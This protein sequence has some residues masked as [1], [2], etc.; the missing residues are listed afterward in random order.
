M[1]TITL[2]RGRRRSPLSAEDRIA[3]WV[4]VLPA[5]LIYV[6]F[7]FGPV[8][9][10]LFISFFRWELVTPGRTFIGLDNYRALIHDED[11]W[12]AFRNTVWYSFGV[13]PVQ[14]ATGLVLAVLANRKIRG[15]TFFRTSFYFPS[16]SS[17][18]VIAIIFV[19]MFSSRG[20][21]N[22][23]LRALSLPT[24]RP[25]WLANP[26]GVIEL[27]LGTFGI[28]N[29]SVWL[30]GPSVALL[31]IMML[32]IWTTT[33]TLMVIFLAGLQNLP[34]DVYE[35]AALDGASRY[36]GFRDIT[37]PLLKPVILFVLTI[38]FIGCFQVFD[39][40]WIMSEGGPRKTTTTLVYLI[41]TEAFQFGSGFGYAASIAM[42]LLVLI[43]AIY[44]IQRRIVGETVEQ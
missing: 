15:R 32:N 34:T 30:E 44:W 31:T 43:L 6:V 1:A 17:S 37:V 14:T 38:G 16:I 22:Y 25:V 9:Y 4:F 41:Y 2:R 5:M 36:R 28:E 3:G 33:G 35:A 8:L 19:W 12:I 29:V 10:A 39:Q 20:L 23:V 27:A 13:V 40:I 18:V 24:P 21:V 11:F 7:V 26:R 42:V